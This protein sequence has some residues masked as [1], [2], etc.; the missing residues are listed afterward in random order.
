MHSTQAKV[1]C[2]IPDCFLANRPKC[3]S[4]SCSE[5]TYE[6]DCNN[7]PPIPTD[8][9]AP[10]HA[11]CTIQDVDRFTSAD[12]E[13]FLLQKSRKLCNSEVLMFKRSDQLV[14]MFMR[15]DQ[16]VLMFMR[17]GQLVLMF[18]RGDQLVLMFMRGG[19]LVLMFMKGGQLALMFVGSGQS[20]S[21]LYL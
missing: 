19:Q 16:L 5:C 21:C 13:Y 8:C 9:S 18:M 2:Y 1:C 14:L 12:R 6:D 7:N 20:K 15:D 17:D 10:Y 4:C 11:F 3:S